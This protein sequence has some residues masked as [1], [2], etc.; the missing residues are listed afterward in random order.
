L[1]SATRRRFAAA[2]RRVAAVMPAPAARRCRP[3]LTIGCL[4]TGPGM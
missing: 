2:R 1:C 3:K 4:K